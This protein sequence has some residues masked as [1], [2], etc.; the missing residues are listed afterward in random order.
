MNTMFKERKF[1]SEKLRKAYNSELKDWLV[2]E[3]TSLPLKIKC[4]C[5]LVRRYYPQRGIFKIKITAE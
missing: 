4:F 3:N 2:A 5:E 1:I